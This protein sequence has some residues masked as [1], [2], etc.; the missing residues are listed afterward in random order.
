[1]AFDGKNTHAME[2][3]IRVLA[4]REKSSGFELYRWIRKNKKVKAAAIFKGGITSSHY[5]AADG[6]W[7]VAGPKGKHNVGGPEGEKKEAVAQ[8]KRRLKAA[9]HRE[10]GSPEV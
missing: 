7:Q 5:G 1:M 10:D 3:A 4:D 9:G 8:M 2:D 6:G